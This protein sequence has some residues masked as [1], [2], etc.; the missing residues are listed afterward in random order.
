MPPSTFPDSPIFSFKTPAF[1]GIFDI[2]QKPRFPAI[3][4]A[5]GTMGPGTRRGSNGAPFEFRINETGLRSPNALAMNPKPFRH[6]RSFRAAHPISAA[7]AVL[8]ALAPLRAVSAGEAEVL[9][10]FERHCADCHREDEVPIL[11]SGI[12]LL[13]LLSSEEDVA[14]IIDRV[15]RGERARGRMPKS[16]GG[17]GDPGYVAPLSEKE[18]ATLATWAKGELATP[19]PSGSG[20]PPAPAAAAEDER[21]FL[22]LRDEIRAIAA[23]L[24]ALERAR[25]PFA[26]YLTLSNL[27]NLRDAEGRFV[28]SEAQL[29]AY[30]A[31]LGKLVNSVSRGARVVP[32]AAIDERRLV[33]RLDLRDYGW[34]SGEWERIVAKGYPYGLRGI[35]TRAESEI[36][37]LSGSRS[38]WVRGDWFVFA[39]SQPPLYHDLLKLPAT[40][41]E[42]EQQQ[43]VDTL[44]NLRAGRALRAGFRLSGVSQGNRL[45]ER[46]EAATG[47]YWKSYDFT[48][49]VRTGGHDLFRS[50]L[51]PP[52]AGLTRNPDREFHH[53][54]GEVI[55]Q[56]PNGLH[57]YYLATEDGTRIDR[58]PTEIVQDRKRRDGAIINGISCMACHDQG[59]KRA[60]VDEHGRDTIEAIFDEVGPV[61]LAA[62]LDRDERHRV[63]DLYQSAA[64]LAAAFDA[65]ER[66]Y[67]AALAR[68]TPGF[69]QPIDPVSRL[70][71]RFRQ[72]IRVETLAAEFGEED[73]AFLA[74]L[75]ESRDPDLESIAAQFEAGLGFPRPSWIDQF[76]KIAQTFGYSLMDFDP[77][78]YAEYTSGA[79]EAGGNAGK[80]ALNEGGTLRISTDKPSYRK[81]DLLT[82]DV[83]STEG[84]YLRLYHLSAERKLQQIFPNAARTDNFIR[85]GETVTIGS[86][87]RGELR[88]GEFRF[89]MKEPFGTE[90]ILAVASPVQFS[91]KENLTFAAGEVFKGF[92]EG[93]LRE[94]ARRGTKGLEVE[95]TDHEGE[96]VAIRSAPTF[97]A[98]T[99]FTVGP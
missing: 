23:D 48:P 97:T 45:I 85:G 76:K 72:D 56:L 29:D 41:Q 22:P 7:L 4:S 61:A 79:A 69:D 6:A 37:E 88:P 60:K 25:Q 46:H 65:D 78:D 74:R 49:L 81:G 38:A 10:I 19:T 27:A 44:A 13:S 30:R 89:R 28:E 77:V 34:S 20:D 33:Y 52:G 87:G 8:T 42:L 71:N 53:D 63:E 93:D 54:G 32:P 35:D 36:A 82:V 86:K 40:E 31:A 62:G 83:R 66:A 2:D 58:G 94:A 99:V 92:A 95:V 12:N 18:I 96:T 75:K 84:V 70:Y 73:A 21:S 24:R 3:E 14:D 17:P 43:G 55:F 39:A 47:M 11:H 26:R 90:I 57:G 59:M 9:S 68:A 64:A 1:H 91:D 51:G 15:T 67:L 98:R 50:P 16:R 5:S 80:V